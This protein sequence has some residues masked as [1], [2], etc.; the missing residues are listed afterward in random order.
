MDSARSCR[1]AG[2]LGV[3]RACTSPRAR[4][5]TM[6]VAAC[7]GRLTQR[8]PTAAAI[9]GTMSPKARMVPAQPRPTSRVRSPSVARTSACRARRVCRAP[10]PSRT[11]PDIAAA[12]A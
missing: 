12:L 9:I 4:R 2:P 6:L 7:S 8:R 5:R 1:S 10:S 3:A 11:L